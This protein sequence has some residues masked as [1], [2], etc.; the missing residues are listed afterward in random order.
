[1]S[2]EFPRNNM[3]WVADFTFAVKASGV[4]LELRSD[5]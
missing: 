3:N 2:G 1:M 4:M 5:R